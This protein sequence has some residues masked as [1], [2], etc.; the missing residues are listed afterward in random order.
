[1]ILMNS[2]PKADH[3]KPRSCTLRFLAN[4]CRAKYMLGNTQISPPK[5]T[6]TAHSGLTANRTPPAQRVT[7]H[8]A[9]SIQWTCDGTFGFR[10]KF[11]SPQEPSRSISRMPGRPL[12]HLSS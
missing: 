8:C 1:M 4:S 6:D 7:S 3:T 9:V 12:L 11:L 5:H 2:T 10:V